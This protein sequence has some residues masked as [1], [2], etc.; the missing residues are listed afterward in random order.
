MPAARSAGRQRRWNTES[1]STTPSELSSTPSFP[2]ENEISIYV[3]QNYA[4]PTAYLKR[5]TLRTDGFASIKAPYS[6]GSVTTKPF[7]F[8]GKIL[9]LNFAT[10]APGY[11]K[12]EIRDK[13]NTPIPGYTL[14]E[15]PELIGNYTDHPASWKKG[16][17]V[18]ALAGKPIRL[19]IKIKDANL[20][21][22]KF[23]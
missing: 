3:Q 5:Y 15:T 23:E 21:S 7:T 19:H 12:I 20:Y 14:K 16:N 22:L 1:L 10:S 18:S 4:Q 13:N 2:A 6:G 17:D 8:T 11:I 9:T